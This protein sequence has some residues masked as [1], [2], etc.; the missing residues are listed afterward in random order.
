MGLI[1]KVKIIGIDDPPDMI[2]SIRKG[3]VFGSF[4][5]NF[6]KQGYEAV[7]NIVDYFTKKP[8]PPKTDAGIVLITKSN[9]DNYLPDMWKTVALKGKPYPNLK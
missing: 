5:Q 8:F 1:G 6:Q 7:R 3:E 9:V 2:E 4:N